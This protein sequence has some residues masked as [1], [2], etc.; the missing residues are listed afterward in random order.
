MLCNK[1]QG[2]TKTKN[3][4]SKKNGNIYTVYE[5]LGSC[6][7]DQNPNWKHSFFPPKN[8]GGKQTPQTQQTKQTGAG[9]L[10]LENQMALVEKVDRLVVMVSEIKQAVT[11]GLSVEPEELVPDEEAPF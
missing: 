2:P 8:N 11:G 4:Q 6:V 1:C 10:I 7:S 3:I 5:C 9:T